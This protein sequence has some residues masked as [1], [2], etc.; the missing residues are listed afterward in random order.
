MSSSD[1]NSEVVFRP[2]VLI[3]E[4]GSMREPSQ[5]QSGMWS[6]GSGPSAAAILHLLSHHQLLLNEQ[7][8]ESEAGEEETWRDG[9]HKNHHSE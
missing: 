7:L 3:G 6:L 8:P 5:R 2:R 1:F 4:F 9:G